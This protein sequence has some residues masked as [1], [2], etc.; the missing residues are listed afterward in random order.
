MR[1]KFI[2]LL[3]LLLLLTA[4][5]KKADA[6]YLIGGD[7]V[8]T[9]GYEDGEVKGEPNCHYFEEGLEFKDEEKVY[10]ATFDEDFYYFLSDSKNRGKLTKVT[11]WP[12]GPGMFVYN[13]HVIGENEMAFE[14]ADPDIDL[15]CY[16][17]RQ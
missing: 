5:N 14:I 1:Y 12:E 16:L 7:W 13:I 17:E 10:N 4:C 8:A 3:S 2:L 15:S 11:F 6:E 9:A